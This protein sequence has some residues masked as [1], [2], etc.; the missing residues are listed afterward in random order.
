MWPITSSAT[1]LYAYKI[2]YVCDQILQG[3]LY[4]VIITITSGNRNHQIQ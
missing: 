2:V 4:K 3:H 1:K